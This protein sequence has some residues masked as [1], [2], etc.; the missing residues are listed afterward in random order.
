MFRNVSL[1]NN[2]SMIFQATPSLS[3]HNKGLMHTA[4]S[5]N[6]NWPYDWSEFVTYEPITDANFQDCSEFVVLDNQRMPMH[7]RSHQR[8]EYFCGYEYVGGF[9]GSNHF[10]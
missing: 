10:Q 6:P 2:M 1:D 8:L 4:F 7:L 3:E 5:S 9:Q